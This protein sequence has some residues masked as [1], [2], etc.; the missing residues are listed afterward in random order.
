VDGGAFTQR[1]TTR[2]FVSGIDVLAPLSNGAVVAL[3]DSIT[4]GYQEPA[5]GPPESP[6]GIDADG[7]WPDVLARRLRAA[8][9]PLSVL[10]AGISG[11]RVLRDGTA[12]GNPDVYGPA[13]IRRLDADVLSQAG[14][15][16]VILF[17]G[18][19]DL[20]EAPTAT[21]E[22]LLGGYRQ[23]IDV[24][25]SRGLRV[26]QGT[27]TPVGG[28]DGA[29]P[30]AEAKRQAINTWIREQSPADAV[31]DFDA[32]VRDP[33]DPSRIDPDFD[34][35]DHLHFNLAGHLVMGNAVPL[36]LLLDPTCS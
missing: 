11:N 25:H 19:N 21:V 4:D 13:A 22:E 6:E 28:L 3:G 17:E 36:E 34:G 5:S 29:P 30:D 10:N 8:S 7:R 23:L 20:L 15:T 2:P 16:T 26:L 31:I 32:A 9:R 1:T 33:A 35:G 24:M 27:L 12:G 14:V 18:N